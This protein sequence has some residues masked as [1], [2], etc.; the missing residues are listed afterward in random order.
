[1]VSDV[2]QFAR[3]EIEVPDIR[4][5]AP[6]RD[7]GQ[8]L[9]IWRQTGLV[10]ESGS[11]GQSLDAGPVG[12]G[13]VDPRRSRSVRSEDNPSPIGRERRVVIERRVRKK[14]ACIF[15]V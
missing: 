14:R 6:R 5:P 3:G 7:E 4:L 11:V 2:A 10:F 13:T 8:R 15:P 1:M 9:S 12:P